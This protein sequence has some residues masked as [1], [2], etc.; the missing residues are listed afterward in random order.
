M[1]GKE[2]NGEERKIDE[3]CAWI[4]QE[5]GSDLAAY[6]TV[7]QVSRK[8]E[9]RHVNGGISTRTGLIRQKASLGLTGAAIR[10]GRPLKLEQGW[11]ERD[12]FKLGE[13]IFMTEKLMT[14]AA[15]PLASGQLTDQAG[16]LLIGRRE[17]IGYGHEQLQKAVELTK[18]I[19][20]CGDLL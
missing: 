16:V 20:G 5:T 17:N 15:I 7:D 11:D 1:I 8:L 2:E 4:R 3:L 13:A 9:W 12:R 10:A 18:T 14:A 6:G 19:T